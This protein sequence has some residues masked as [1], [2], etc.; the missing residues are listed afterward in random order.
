MSCHAIQKPSESNRGGIMSLLDERNTINFLSEIIFNFKRVKL[1]ANIKV[2]T[3]LRMS[4][5]LNSVPRLAVSNNKSKK[6][7]LLPGFIEQT[8]AKIEKH[9]L[10]WHFTYER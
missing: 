4:D 2:S 9:I 1:T 10:N 5:S 7:F 3:W 8:Y 6:G